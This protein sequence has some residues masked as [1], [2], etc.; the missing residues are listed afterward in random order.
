MAGASDLEEA[1]RALVGGVRR[2]TTAEAVAIQLLEAPEDD[3]Q[4]SRVYG[5]LGPDYNG[6]VEGDFPLAEAIER[7]LKSGRGIFL[8]DV[9][10]VANEGDAGA[11]II[12]ERYGVRSS[13][14]VP[15]RVAGRTT[16]LLHVG[17]LRSGAF[18]EALLEPLQVLADYAG[19]VVEQAR[20]HHQ[21]AV[22][23]RRL[24]SAQRVSA[25][26]NRAVDLG[27][28][29]TNAIAEAVTTVGAARGTVALVDRDC[30]LLRDHEGLDRLGS[31]VE[32]ITHR[33]YSEPV[34]EE[35]VYAQVVRTGEQR[36]YDDHGGSGAAGQLALTP[37]PYGGEIIGVLTLVWEQEPG[38]GE[39]D[40][41]LLRFIAE[42]IGNAIARAR[43]LEQ[44]SHQA[45]HDVLTNLPNRAL[46]LETLSR[47][48]ARAARQQLTHAVLFVDGDGFK[49]VNDS[50]GHAAGDEVLISMAE[51]MRCCVREQDVVA[52]FAGDEFA[53]LLDTVA[54]AHEAEQVAERIIADLSAPFPVHGYEAQTSCS[55]GIA[56]SVAGTRAPEDLLRAA[57]A[58]KYRAKRSGGRRYA[59]A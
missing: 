54:G 3:Q 41:T 28:L 23:L 14:N 49:A 8:P 29:Q 16:G 39:G 17:A 59:L 30:A 10:R 32:A 18:S 26:V 25:A 2:L 33:L 57:D 9:E 43:L 36:V 6:W 24:E 44:L 31:A 52:R 38:P 1:L 40:L 27:T 7:T 19:G 45:T 15:L 47:A 13:L 56:L 12:P 42:Q 48:V 37:I 35:D 51:R 21:A 58:A 50:L 4:A 11:R 34:P 5:S 55:I 20:L 46:F 22:R 53:V